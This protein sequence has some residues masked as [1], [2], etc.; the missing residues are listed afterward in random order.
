MSDSNARA[1][2]SGIGLIPFIS[3]VV[4]AVSFYTSVPA[5][6]GLTGVAEAALLGVGTGVVSYGGGAVGALVGF[7]CGAV[8]GGG[9][10][11]IS[12]LPVGGN[13]L[14]RGGVGA[15]GVGVV[16]GLA[17]SLGGSIY[18]GIAGHKLMNDKVLPKLIEPAAPQH[19]D[20]E[21]KVSD[22]S[23]VVNGVKLRV[24]YDENATMGKV[25]PPVAAPVAAVAIS[26]PRLKAA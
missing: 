14:K 10:G 11:A 20:T 26:M 25:L 24:L 21:K 8:V 22:T 13:S 6:T 7:F 3:G 23:Y 15:L 17:L 2:G 5:L 18:G 1:A 19:S 4:S 16:G 9:L 12:A